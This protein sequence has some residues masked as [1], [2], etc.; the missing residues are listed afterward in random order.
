MVTPEPL[1]EVAIDDGVATISLCDPAS[2]NAL[3][4]GMV[5]VLT[6][7]CEELG[8]D[9]AVRVVVLC[10]AADVFCS[11]APP[12]LLAELVRGGGVAP[13]DI[14]L[15]RVLL[16]LPI[17]S[18]AAVE[19]HAVGGGL[20]LALSADIIILARESRFGMPFMDLG[21]TPGMGTTRLLEHV[22]SP[23]I[24]HELLLTGEMRRGD[25]FAGSGVNHVLPRS[26]VRPKAMDLARRI[27]EKPRS[28]LE[29]LKRALSLPR[30]RI[31][32]ETYTLETLMHQVSF[33]DLATRQ[34]QSLEQ[35]PQPQP[36]RQNMGGDVHVE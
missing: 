4:A 12:E 7:R 32:E 30:R 22:L 10:G 23:A 26:A 24:A 35:R 31:F 36:Q 21:F 16:D 27:A 25:A 13:T 19:G 33:H 15:A 6:R 2:G 28:A 9:P 34:R 20:A 8:R 11:G 1:V 14:R 3:S 5:E 18:L 29:L 17:P